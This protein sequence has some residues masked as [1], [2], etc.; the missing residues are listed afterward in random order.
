MARDQQ[1]GKGQQRLF[2][3]LRDLPA[4]ALDDTLDGALSPAQEGMADSETHR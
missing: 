1:E 3:L 2:L 4:H